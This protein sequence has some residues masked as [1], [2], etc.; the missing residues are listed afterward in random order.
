METIKILVVDDHDLM[1][2][3]LVRILNDVDN[4]SVIGEADSGEE[5]ISLSRMKDK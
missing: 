1:R 4:F 3:G 5:A 2:T